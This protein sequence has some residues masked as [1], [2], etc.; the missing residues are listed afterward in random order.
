MQ[1]QVSKFASKGIRSRTRD[2]TFYLFSDVLIYVNKVTLDQEEQEEDVTK[3]KKEQK[4]AQNTKSRKRRM[5]RRYKQELASSVQESAQNELKAGQITKEEYDNM[6]SVVQDVNVIFSDE[7]PS[8]PRILKKNNNNSS[9]RGLSKS[10]RGLSKNNSSRRGLTKSLSKFGLEYQ[11]SSYLRKRHRQSSYVYGKNYGLTRRRLRGVM[12]LR[13]AAVVASSTHSR[14]SQQKS[15]DKRLDNRLSM[16]RRKNN[17]LERD[18]TRFS[19]QV[20][21]KTWELK[22]DNAIITRRWVHQL[23]D[24]ISALQDKKNS[25]EDD[26]LTYL[27]VCSGLSDVKIFGRGKV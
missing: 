27:P 21:D 18:P 22:C 11:N 25:G 16:S 2:Y 15:F 1:G 24:C 14:S 9:R 5:A 19:I 10:R 6:L 8:S 4:I 7:D 3:I 23:R 17:E 20:S 12:Y 26:C 13:H